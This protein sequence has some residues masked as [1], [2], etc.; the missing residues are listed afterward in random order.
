MHSLYYFKQKVLFPVC[1]IPV[2]TVT[3]MSC[4]AAGDDRGNVALNI[5]CHDITC[6]SGIMPL[7]KDILCMQGEVK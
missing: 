6:Y 3:G 1:L 2:I 5:S 7:C 4:D